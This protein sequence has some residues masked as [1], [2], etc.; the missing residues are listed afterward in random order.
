ML[1]WDPPRLPAVKRAQTAV[2]KPIDG[3]ASDAIANDMDRG[4]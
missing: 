2:V 4:I 1:W 3:V